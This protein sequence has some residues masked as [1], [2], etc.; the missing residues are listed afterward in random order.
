MFGLYLVVKYYLT[1]P[2]I[3]KKKTQ[4]MPCTKFIQQMAIQSMVNADVHN[5][6]V[7][8]RCIFPS[9]TLWFQW[10]KSIILGCKSR[11]QNYHLRTSYM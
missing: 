4:V 2:I 9:K 6:N 3:S 7:K 1:F 8:G 11:D 10:N 5:Q